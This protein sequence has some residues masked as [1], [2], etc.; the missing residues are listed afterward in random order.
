MKELLF[1]LLFLIIIIPDTINAQKDFLK[2]AGLILSSFRNAGITSRGKSTRR[3]D[4]LDNG[5]RKSRSGHRLSKFP[6]VFWN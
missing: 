4:K 6:G 3:L 5:Q 1:V 2:V